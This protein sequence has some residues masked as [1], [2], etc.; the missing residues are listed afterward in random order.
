MENSKVS[1]WKGTLNAGVFLGLVLVLYSLLLYFTD[2]MFNQLL[3]AGVYVVYI[4]GLFMAIKS[5]REN[6]RQGYLS[7]GQALGTGVVV[8]LYAAIISAVFTYVLYTF[9]DPDLPVKM[10]EFT[11]QKMLDRGMPDEQ[12]EM[13]M[14]ISSKLM[15]PWFMSISAVLNGVFLG[16]I[17]SLILGI[18][19]KNEPEHPFDEV[20]AAEE[21]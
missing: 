3:G 16:T 18:F 7:Y 12:V 6:H 20:P 10:L 17:I 8:A 9:I 2:Q 13:S 21:E 5:F 14:K 1:V 11:K 4:A 19:L 15:K